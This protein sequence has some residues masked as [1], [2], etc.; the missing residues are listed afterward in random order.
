V[1][2]RSRGGR[3]RARLL[4]RPSRLEARQ[5][6]GLG[7]GRAEAA[8]L[9]HRAAAR[10]RRRARSGGRGD[11]DPTAGDDPFVRE[12]RAGARRGGRTRLGHLLARR[13]PL[14]AAD[15]A[16]ALQ[17]R[18]HQ[19]RRARARDPRARAGSPRFGPRPGCD[20]G[21]GAAQGARGA[22]RLG[23][24]LRR[25]PPALPRRA[26]GPR[27]ARL[28]PLP[29]GQGGAPEARAL[30]QRRPRGPPPRRPRGL[31]FRWALRQVPETR[32]PERLALARDAG[33]SRRGGELSPGPRRSRAVRNDGGDREPALR[34]GP[35]SRATPDPC[36]PRDRA[37]PGRTRHPRPRR[38]AAGAPPRHPG[39]AREPAADRGR[40][41]PHRR[42]VGRGAQAP[43]RALA[44]RAGQ[45]RGRLP[46]RPSLVESGAPE[47][48]LAVTA[49]LRALP[50]GRK[51]AAADLRLGVVDLEA[52]ILLGRPQEVA[53]RA[54]PVVA[55]AKARGL[56]LLA[57]R[58]LLQESQ[59]QDGLG[60]SAASRALA[61]EARRLFTR[62]GEMAGVARSLNLLCLAQFRE[63]RHDEAERLCGE[64]ARLY[65]RVGSS[66]GV[67]RALS[68]L[69]ASRQRRGLIREARA[70]FAQALD[71]EDHG[72]VGDRLSKAR[73]LHNL[74]NLDGELGHL[75][76]AEDGLRKA[77]AILRDAG[78]ELSLMRGLNALSV[79]LQK[80]GA[81]G[82]AGALADE[83]TR[84]ARQVGSPRE[85]ANLLWLQGGL[86]TIR[87]ETGRARDWYDQAER[88]L[89]EVR[90]EGLLA[91]FVAD[92][93]Q[94][95]EPSVRTCRELES[96]ERELERLGDRAATEITVDVSRCWREAG[97]PRDAK[98]W[99][100]LAEKTATASQ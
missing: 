98:R 36:R 99:L 67:A 41:V 76:E 4:G 51:P 90:E 95:A 1:P 11:A 32:R 44:A 96:S 34:R 18:Q 74:A 2:F 89:A 40:G 22:L 92:R 65:R 42:A 66:T 56:P 54:G 19:P 28:A 35:R 31:A 15:R 26:A 80:R 7:T 21:Q 10:S 9:R 46:S 75:R 86:A 78:N 57:A 73:Y 38:G 13:R 69:G 77:I 49:K 85:L 59:A 48:A 72:I 37:V 91:V 81:L 30:A 52:L 24:G 84:L 71:I 47:E 33:R 55:R 100:D 50:A 23:G 12:P 61:E 79:V 20:L 39:V 88:Q 60:R 6:P 68:I 8:R 87:G 94:L 58:A 16:E 64:G 63:S 62:R 17:A 43:A 45:L 70:T 97:S 53:E 14:R 25:R 3:A 5:R 27:A 83:A 93:K 82:E 29:A